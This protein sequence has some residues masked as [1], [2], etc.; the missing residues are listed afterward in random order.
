MQGPDSRSG[1]RT[2]YTS[3]RMPE[4]K[5]CEIEIKLKVGSLRELLKRLK[6]LGARCHG[7]VFE[8]NTLYD[9]AERT[10]WQQGKL[11]RLRVETRVATGPEERPHP[12][13]AE[14]SGKGKGRETG[15]RVV[16][17]YKGRAEGGTG[18]EERY[19]VREEI[20]TE[21]SEPEGMAR[22]LEGMGYAAVFRYE[23]FR[24]EYRLPEVAGAVLELDETPAGLYLEVEGTR[25][26]I[27]QVAELL[28]CST[29]EYLT[30]SYWDIHERHCRER[31]V[32]FKDMLFAN[33]EVF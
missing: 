9:T 19:K 30:E 2:K 3:G 12:P 25:E 14:G 23:K 10:L 24:S 7:R 29:A 1:R 16:L 4:F 11:L 28:G 31:G 21:V 8:E 27:D 20:E 5:N 18:Q 17:T 22:I 26:S 32:H 33:Q 15:P 13:R 6:K